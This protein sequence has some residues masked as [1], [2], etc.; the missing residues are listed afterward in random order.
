MELEERVEGGKLSKRSVALNERNKTQNY[1]RDI[2]AGTRRR[3]AQKEVKEGPSID[4]FARRETRPKIIWHHGKERVDGK[5][6]QHK[7]KIVA[8]AAPSEEVT[9]VTMPVVALGAQWETGA[10][11]SA[12]ALSIMEIRSNVKRRLGF[13]PV[14]YAEQDKKQRYL[15]VVCGHLPPLGSEA[16]SMLRKGLSLADALK[17]IGVQNPAEE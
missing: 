8:G 10:D 3:D 15:S 7:G 13:D 9:R 2:N 12:Q 5:E 4:P 6:Y 11:M 14:E 16:R 17:K 1:M